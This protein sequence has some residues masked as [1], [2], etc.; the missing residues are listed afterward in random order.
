VLRDIENLECSEDFR[1]RNFALSS[2][3][4]DLQVRKYPYYKITRDGFS[5]LVMGFTGKKAAEWKEKFIA[6]FNMMEAKLRVPAAPAFK[7]PASYSEALRELANVV[8]EK[9]ALAEKVEVMSPKAALVDA[10]YAALNSMKVHEFH[11]TLNGVNSAKAKADL[12]RAG[13]FYT[14]SEGR[15]RV[16]SKYRDTHFRE[17]RNEEYGNIDIY[18]REM[19]RNLCT[20]LY[21]QGKL[22]M[23][24]GEEDAWMYGDRWGMGICESSTRARHEACNG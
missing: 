7:L 23:K 24:R 6:A 9:D 11:R 8:E 18:V 15:Y 22:T 20:R 16:Y 4:V 3:S 19:G 17:K 5:F 12:K 14:D 2:Y 10:H 21:R 13:I 1:E